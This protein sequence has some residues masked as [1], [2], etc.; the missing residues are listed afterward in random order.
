[1]CV[2][3]L[4]SYVWLL[5]TLW[6]VAC[7]ASPSTGFSRQEYWSG[8]PSPPLGDLPDP[9]IEYVSFSI[10]SIDRRVFLPLAP[11]E[12]KDKCKKV[13]FY[14]LKEEKLQICKFANKKDL[15][16]PNSE[17]VVLL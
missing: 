3:G 13:S 2:L 1:M 10:F 5:A 14:E 12:L 6:I 16:I 17:A 11:P 15:Q 9:G 8:F 4:F 7:Q